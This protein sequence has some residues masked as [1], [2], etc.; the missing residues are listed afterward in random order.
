MADD[1]AAAKASLEW[2]SRSSASGT[3]RGSLSR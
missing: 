1:M 2:L 3:G